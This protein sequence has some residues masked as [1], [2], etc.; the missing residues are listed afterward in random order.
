MTKA[1]W[2]RFL[3]SW[4]VY[5][6]LGAIP[7]S[8][9]GFAFSYY[10]SPSSL[11]DWATYSYNTLVLMVMVSPVSGML[12]IAS[13]KLADWS[14]TRHDKRQ[15]TSGKCMKC[16][17]DLTGNE[18]GRCPECGEPTLRSPSGRGTGEA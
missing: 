2:K 12:A 3:V 18:S 1:G 7:L 6:L 15:F 11:R 5:S 9:V 17:Y 4:L 14:R 13:A 16:G 8:C 10:R